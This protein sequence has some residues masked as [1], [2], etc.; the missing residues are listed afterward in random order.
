MKALTHAVLALWFAA[1][2]AV[3]GSLVVTLL[4]P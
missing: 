4:W 1:A 3:F 2:T